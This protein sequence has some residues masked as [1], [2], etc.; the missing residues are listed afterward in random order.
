MSILYSIVIPLKNE[1]GN[2]QELLEEVEACMQPLNQPWELICI[3]DGSTDNS[4]EILEKISQQKNW[5]RVVTF[6][7]NFGQSSAFTA[8]FKLARGEYVITLDGDRQNDPADIPKLIA[9]LDNHDMVCGYRVNR[10]DSCVKKITSFLANKVRRRLC[11]DGVRDT[12]CSLKIYRTSALKEIKMF[13]GMHRFLPALFSNEGFSVCEIP[14]N[15]RERT[16]G[17]SHY[18]F[19]NRSFNTIADMLA[20]RWMRKRHLQYQIKT[21]V[22]KK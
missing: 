10:R 3:N 15:H 21:I 8:G 22:E 6:T 11:Q 2:I 9:A 17:T 19:F 20:V 18:S 7:Q 14:V 16:R 4:Q 1:A 5:L 12:G 13:Q